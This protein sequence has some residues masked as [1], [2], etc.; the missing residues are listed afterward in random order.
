MA[1]GGS[2]YDHVVD[3]VTWP[4]KVKLVIPIRLQRNNVS[5]KQLF[6]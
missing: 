2:E 5:W 1:Y 4:R 6:S 3:D